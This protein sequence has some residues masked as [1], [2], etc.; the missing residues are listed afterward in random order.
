MGS[1]LGLFQKETV[2]QIDF[3]LDFNNVEPPTGPSLEIYEHVHGILQRSNEILDHLQN[4]QAC[5]TQIHTAITDPTTTNENAAWDVLLPAVDQ[6]KDLFLYSIEIG[7]ASKQ[8]LPPLSDAAQLR[9]Q[10]ALAKLLCELFNF[11]LRFDDLKMIKPE[12]QNDFSFFRRSM[13]KLKA[14]GNAERI[15]VADDVANKMSLFYAYPTPMMNML[16]QLVKEQNLGVAN[17]EIVAGL[18]LLAN[19]CLNMVENNEFPDDPDLNLF[20]L[21]AMTAAIV[22]V[23]HVSENGGVFSR[24]SPVNIKTAI[25]T[26]REKD[27]TLGTEGLLNCLKYTTQTLNSEATPTSIKNLLV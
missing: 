13:G 10:A 26:L 14:S 25:L 16:T 22:L 19:V 27:D 15:N 11:I 8:L 4:Y 5:T 1:L 23:D 3:F 7:E 21:R 24:R 18:S 20:C 6:L 9:D 2:H 12:I 17:E